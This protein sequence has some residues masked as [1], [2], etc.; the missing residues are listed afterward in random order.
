RF[1]F[2]HGHGLRT[3]LGFS[4]Q[5]RLNGKIRNEDAG[6][7]HENRWCWQKPNSKP[8]TDSA[9]FADKNRKIGR[10]HANPR[11]VAFIQ[12]GLLVLKSSFSRIARV[13]DV[14]HARDASAGSRLRFAFLLRLGRVKVSLMAHG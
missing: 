11:G 5:N 10:I 8:A 2:E 9:D 12:R 3:Q 1:A 6:K 13:Y 4:A 7:R 14:R